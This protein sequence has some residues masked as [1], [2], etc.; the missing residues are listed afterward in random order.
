MDITGPVNTTSDAMLG[1]PELIA[2]ALICLI[3]IVLAVG[4][5]KAFTNKDDENKK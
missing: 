2:G 4:L 3:A 5:F 1:I